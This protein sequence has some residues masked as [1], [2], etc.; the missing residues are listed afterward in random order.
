M[1]NIDKY[2]DTLFDICVRDQN[3]FMVTKNGDILPC[4]W[5][6]E[7]CKNCKFDKCFTP[8]KDLRMDWLNADFVPMFYIDYTDRAFLNTLLEGYNYFCRVYDSMG[9]CRLITSKSKPVVKNNRL[10]N[11]IS[12]V[13]LTPF[14]V[15]L[16]FVGSTDHDEV[17]TLEEILSLPKREKYN[18]ED[19]QNYNRL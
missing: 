19:A 13:D 14:K 1:R 2:K 15:R 16:P 7:D 8:C 18:H 3:S 4:Y 6:K 10:Y 12:Y 11:F 17:W 9:T 5:E